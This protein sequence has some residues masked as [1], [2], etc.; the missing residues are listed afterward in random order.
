[1]EEEEQ[2]QAQLE[3]R[4]KQEEILMEAEIQSAM[5][6][7]RGKEHKILPQSHDAQKACQ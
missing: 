5:A 1:M 6:Q 7:R 2:L 3:E 4:R